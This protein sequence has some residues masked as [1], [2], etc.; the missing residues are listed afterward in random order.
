M[1][2][3]MG[4]ATVVSD[5]RFSISDILGAD[6]VLVFQ[7]WA[8]LSGMNLYTQQQ[9]SFKAVEAVPWS[10]SDRSER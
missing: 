8:V 3:V 2:C 4:K 7:Q 1:D 9:V 6:Y 5:D 10:Q